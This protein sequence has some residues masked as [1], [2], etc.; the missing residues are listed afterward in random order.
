MSIQV[1]PS[2]DTSYASDRPPLHKYT[3][4]AEGSIGNLLSADLK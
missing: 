4:D 2:P 3:E 1:L